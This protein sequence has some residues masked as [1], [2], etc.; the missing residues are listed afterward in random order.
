MTSTPLSLQFS[1]S[2]QRQGATALFANSDHDLLN[3]QALDQRFQGVR[4]EARSCPAPL[5]RAGRVGLVKADDGHAAPRKPLKRLVYDHRI[6]RRAEDQH[7]V[8]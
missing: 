3:A 1:S 4:L 5:R 2:L 8:P 7:S 6:S